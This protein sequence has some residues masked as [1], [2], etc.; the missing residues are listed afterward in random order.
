MAGRRERKHALN[1]TTAQGNFSVRL[2]DIPYS[3][4]QKYLDGRVI[5]DRVP[6]SFQIASTPDEQDYPAVAADKNGNLWLAYVEFRH[7]PD[8]DRIRGN[9][10]ERPKTSRI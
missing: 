6:G 5:A 1:V 10:Q 4:S 2:S 3:K 8:H 9:Y 7:N